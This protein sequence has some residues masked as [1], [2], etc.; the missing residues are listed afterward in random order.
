VV[1]ENNTGRT[2]RSD[3]YKYCVYTSGTIRK[4]LV[5]LSSDPGEMKNLAG[6]PQFRKALSQHRGYMKKWIVQSNNTEAKSF[7]ITPD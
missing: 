1:A 4:S 5:D 7:T 6:L 3:H 2:L